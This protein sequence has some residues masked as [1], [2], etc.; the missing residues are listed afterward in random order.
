[1]LQR[2]LDELNED[3]AFLTFGLCQEEVLPDLHLRYLDAFWQKEFSEDDLGVFSVG[4]Q[5]PVRRRIRS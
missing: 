5:Y 2:T 3:I 4:R 1:M